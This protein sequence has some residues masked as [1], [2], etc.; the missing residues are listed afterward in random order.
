MSLLER[1]LRVSVAELDMP[2]HEPERANLTLD[3]ARQMRLR[4]ASAAARGDIASAQI[5]ERTLHVK[6]LKA[7]ANG[8]RRPRQLA[9]I[10][11]SSLEL[12]FDRGLTGGE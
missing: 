4:V 11:A 8:H 6:V 5:D 12:A 9:V 1:T 10:A 7:I 3:E 2:F